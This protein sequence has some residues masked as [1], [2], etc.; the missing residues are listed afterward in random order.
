MVVHTLRVEVLD[1]SI[2]TCYNKRVLKSVT[3]LFGISLSLVALGVFIF[4]VVSFFIM[5]YFR[6]HRHAYRVTRYRVLLIVYFVKNSKRYFFYFMKQVENDYRTE[7]RRNRA[8]RK[9]P[10]KPPY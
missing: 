2:K 9:Q 7:R 8:P 1:F 3:M 10:K 4:L 5:L 6:G